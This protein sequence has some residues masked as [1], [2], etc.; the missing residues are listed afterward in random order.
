[1][2]PLPSRAAP[3]LGT[4]LERSLLRERELK[5]TLAALR[6]ELARAQPHGEQPPPPA[7]AALRVRPA[8]R[9]GCDASGECSVAALVRAVA[10]DNTV[11]ATFGNAKQRHFTENWVYHLQQLG[12]GGLLVGMMNMRDTAPEH[13]AA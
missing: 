5:G 2:P 9:E 7:A 6:H 8:A 11:F 3:P 10:V 12:V 1:M 13:T 4:Q